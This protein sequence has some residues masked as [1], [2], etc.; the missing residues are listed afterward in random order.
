MQIK[1]NQEHDINRNPEYQLFLQTFKKPNIK[2]LV[3]YIFTAG[4]TIERKYS[5]RHDKE[6]QQKEQELIGRITELEQ[7]EQNRIYEELIRLKQENIIL[8][9]AIRKHNIKV[10]VDNS[11]KFYRDKEQN[12][13]II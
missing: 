4:K 7:Q 8:K 10:V 13:E 9:E 5:I 12:R 1:I 11:N 6:C 3:N 2:L